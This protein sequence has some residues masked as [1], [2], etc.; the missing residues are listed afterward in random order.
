M[1]Q[2]YK[3]EIVIKRIFYSTEIENGGDIFYEKERL[4]QTHENSNKSARILVIH[5]GEYYCHNSIIV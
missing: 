1:P 4:F 3:M 5:S 2:E